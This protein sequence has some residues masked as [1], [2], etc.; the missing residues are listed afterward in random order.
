MSESA[1]NVNPIIGTEKNQKNEIPYGCCHCGCGA[2][3]PI[4]KQ[5]CKS[6]G[7][8]KGLPHK[9][10]F[11]H[12]NKNKFGPSSTRWNGG[13]STRGDGR[14][15]VYKKNHPRSGVRNYVRQSHLIVEKAI[16]KFLP[17][18]VEI[19]HFDGDATNDDNKNL[20]ACEDRG[21]HMSLH[22]RTRAY[23]A[24]GNANW[25]KCIRCKKYDDPINLLMRKS[26][27]MSYHKECERKYNR[28]RYKIR[29]RRADNH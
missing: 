29:S 10:I 23:K 7:F 28:E 1:Q 12:Q 22:Q 25:R 15:L 27:Q 24:C 3:A 18:K 20:V 5:T 19:H 9:F 14:I 2:V 17:E 8:V 4:I 13:T 21:Y 16:G 26:D 6:R 11:G